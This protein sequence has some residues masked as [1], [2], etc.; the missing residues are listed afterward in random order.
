VKRKIEPA[1]G[2]PFLAKGSG[3]GGGRDPAE[4][5]P[6]RLTRLELLQIPLFQDSKLVPLWRCGQ[7]TMTLDEADSLI[8]AGVD[9][10]NARYGSPVFNEWAVLALHENAGRILGYHGP[11]RDD[12]QKHFAADFGALREDLDSRQFG[13]GDF[14]FARHAGGTRFDAFL[15]L[16]RGIYLLCNNTHASMEVIA[17]NPRWLA[18]QVPFVELSDKFRA[19]PLALKA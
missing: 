11:R 1:S 12:F 8:S 14:E 6:A 3:G 5:G 9:Q 2:I 7:Q 4:L 10:M 19:N 13:V 17:K 15:V 16:G 18:A